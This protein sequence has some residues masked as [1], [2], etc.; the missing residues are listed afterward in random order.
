MAM[1]AKTMRLRG[2][3]L[4]CPLIRVLG[5]GNCNQ[6][7]SVANSVFE[8]IEG[9]KLHILQTRIANFTGVF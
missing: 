3:D 5:G 2:I 8:G 1:A 6:K 7:G 4:G 9:F